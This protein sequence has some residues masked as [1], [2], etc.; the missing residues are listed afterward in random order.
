L[1]AVL[2]TAGSTGSAG[3]I[4]EFHVT[5]DSFTLEVI[6]ARDISSRLSKWGSIPVVACIFPLAAN[7]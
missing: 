3:N 4:P 1:G 5:K 7:N 2:A 6:S